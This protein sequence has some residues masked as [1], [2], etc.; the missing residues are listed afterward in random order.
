MKLGRLRCSFCRKDETKVSKLVAGARAYICNECAAAA[1]RIMNGGDDDLP[2]AARPAA[3]RSLFARAR[4]FMRG[5]GARRVD[6]LG[7]AG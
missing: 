6:S 4:R 7:V 1:N 2:R 3:R 5:G